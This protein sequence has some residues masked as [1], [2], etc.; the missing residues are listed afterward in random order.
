MA[1]ALAVMVSPR[2]ARAQSSFPRVAANSSGWVDF[3]NG[4]II[5]LASSTS[6]ADGYGESIIASPGDFQARLR[7]DPTANFR[8]GAS[9]PCVAGESDCVGPFT[10]WGLRFTASHL[11]AAGDSTQ[12]DI[13][14]DTSFAATHADY[15]FDWDSALNDST[16]QFLQDYVFNVGTGSALPN[17]PCGFM[18]TAHFVVSASNASGREGSYPEDPARAPQCITRSGWYTFRHEF[19]ADASGNLKVDMSVIKTATGVTVA[20]W[21]FH[22]AC[23]PPQSAGLCTE[24]QPLPIAAVGGNAFGWFAN[25]EI[26]MLP[27][28]NIM[29]RPL[30][31]Q[32]AADC[33]KGGWKNFADPSFKSQEACE[34]FAELELQD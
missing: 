31:P 21:S 5:R 33:E 34:S 6:S 9:G 11:P 15:R 20:N 8:Q 1:I 22:P 12:V 32:S 2:V 24:D 14:L 16:G 26:D 27:V 7:T 4:S 23:S 10:D 30:K 18:K 19:H 13:Y 25:Q 29:L 17:D 3:G 28:A